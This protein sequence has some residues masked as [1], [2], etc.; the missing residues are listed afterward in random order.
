METL[1]RISIN[2]VWLMQSIL[3]ASIIWLAKFLFNLCLLSWWTLADLIKIWNYI[4][5]HVLFRY[6][7]S[8]FEYKCFPVW[9]MLSDMVNSIQHF[10]VS[11]T[12][13][14]WH[15]L[16]CLCM[17]Y[18]IKD[19][20]MFADLWQMVLQVLYNIYCDMVCEVILDLTVHLTPER[21]SPGSSPA[22][23]H[24]YDDWWD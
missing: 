6:L 5:L 2:V 16:T 21:H 4:I 20:P 7:I 9:I 24:P 14:V 22:S 3:Q 10:L 11:L 1:P 17:Y 18:W 23:T 8:T 15:S 12:F 19:R 13:W